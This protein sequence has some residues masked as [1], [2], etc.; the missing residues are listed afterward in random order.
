MIHCQF[1]FQT[2]VL[3]VIFWNSQER[4]WSRDRPVCWGSG[5]P[6]VWGSGGSRRV[7][8]TGCNVYGYSD[9]GYTGTRWFFGS[10]VCQGPLTCLSVNNWKGV[11]YAGFSYMDVQQS[12]VSVGCWTRGVMDMASTI[13]IS[14]HVL[15]ELPFEKPVAN[16][17]ATI[18]IMHL[19]FAKITF[20]ITFLTCNF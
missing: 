19:I 18:L 6:T 1:S 2:S 20:L 16:D 5:V 11:G 10:S 7:S 3:W 8:S 12:L 4:Y 14:G 13:P 17:L 9:P 15:K